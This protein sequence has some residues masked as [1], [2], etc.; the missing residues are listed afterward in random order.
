MAGKWEKDPCSQDNGGIQRQPD[1]RRS[2]PSKTVWRYRY[3][4][5]DASDQRTSWTTPPG[6]ENAHKAVHK[7]KTDMMR[8]REEGTLPTKEDRERPLRAVYDRLSELHYADKGKELRPS[9]KAWHDNAWKHVEAYQVER[10][11][12][13]Y[14]SLADVPL[15]ALK[16]TDL[17]AF[18]ASIKKPPTR[19]AVMQ[20]VRR[21]L[22][23]ALKEEWVPRNVAATIARPEK[24]RR[25]VEPLTEEEVKVIRQHI[26]ERY[27]ALIDVL[28]FA[29]LR[30]GEALAL[31][32]Q[33][34]NGHIE[35]RRNAV[36]V[37]GRVVYG[38]PKTKGSCRDVPLPSWLR[39]ELHEHAA[40]YGVE[41]DELL[42]TQKPRTG[43]ENAPGAPVRPN[44]FR[45]REFDRAVKAAKLVRDE[46]ITPHF[47]RHTYASL[48]LKRGRTVFEV[49]QLMGHSSPRMVEQTYGHPY[50]DA[51]QA[52][53]DT[54]EDVV[55][56]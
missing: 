16:R 42:F 53:A 19:D 30:I 23:L 46:P 29:G 7:M 20:H 11:K 22:Q 15:V 17:I 6:I 50:K 12:H 34:I 41:M 9:T 13:R 32:G 36:E 18:Y 5:R 31:R 2:T 38:E 4:Y 3:L 48:L 43:P 35:V 52:A 49:A 26:P 10:L 54:L 14:P 37:N 25:K 27:R 45:S 8:Q 33:D 51:L 56:A 40:G 21:L 28:A 47:L 44:N 1:P 39:R 55:V 24:T